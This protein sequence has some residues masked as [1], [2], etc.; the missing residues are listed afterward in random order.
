MSTRVSGG[1]ISSEI[2]ISKNSRDGE[3]RQKNVS[4]VDDI[5][6]R[7]VI[8]MECDKLLVQIG[9][10]KMIEGRSALWEA[11]CNR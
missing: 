2:L 9:A 4:F 1:L 8:S 11:I 10:C 7:C 6:S 3:L 5:T